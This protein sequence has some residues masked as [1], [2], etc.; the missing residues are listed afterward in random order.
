MKDN[1]K[2][3]I[4]IVGNGFDLNLS[5]KSN[6][7]D[8]IV[9]KY[10]GGDE[11]L[12]DNLYTSFVKYQD[13]FTLLLH[14]FFSKTNSYYINFSQIYNLLKAQYFIFTYLYFN[15]LNFYSNGYDLTDLKKT[16]WSD[17]EST[18]KDILE[19]S[20]SSKKSDGLI[21]LNWDSSEIL[22][23]VK[24]NVSNLRIDNYRICEVNKLCSLL[25]DDTKCLSLTRN[26]LEQFEKEFHD[27]IRSKTEE[28][29]FN[30]EL[31]SQWAKYIF[32]FVCH[33]SFQN[34]YIVCLSFNY[35]TCNT[36]EISTKMQK[37]LKI[38][39]KKQVWEP[40]YHK[41]LIQ[42][43]NIHGCINDQN[44]D[45][46]SPIIIGIDD[47]ENLDDFKFYE[48]TKSYKIAK[49][50]ANIENNNSILFH[51][52][53]NN[54]NIYFYGHSLSMNDYSY[55]QSMFDKFNL[56]SNNVVLHF[57]YPLDNENENH[58]KFCDFSKIYKLIHH[59][60][61]SFN[62]IDRGNNLFSKLLL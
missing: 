48:F 43:I 17:V 11:K 20:F 28:N 51:K 33:D 42:Y 60:G 18:L 15:F 41:D 40:S 36:E 55:F 32:N 44:N 7:Y 3:Y 46:S 62:N 14:F 57:V 37:K 58:S 26:S 45:I 54:L 25:F 56:Y 30:D 2:N 19:N 8:F 61:S 50:R 4:F 21:R 22:S 53:T 9:Y 29:N 1:D 24:N 49:I 27:Y 39:K 23:S 59:Y 34:N 38:L 31:S 47:S 10:F 35:T 13:P 12:I 6:F 5:L 16:K 52:D